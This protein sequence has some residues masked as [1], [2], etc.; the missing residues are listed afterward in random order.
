MQK[1]FTGAE[2][3]A[4][5]HPIHPALP[6]LEA[7]VSTGHLTQTA[8][9][10][11]RQRLHEIPPG[12][13]P[14]LWL[15]GLRLPDADAAAEDRPLDEEGLVRWLSA[16]SGLPVEKIDPLQLEVET[17]VQAIPAGFARHHSILALRIEQRRAVVACADSFRQREWMPD[18][19]RALGREIQPVLACPSDILRHTAEFYRLSRSVEGAASAEKTAP[20]ENSLEQLLSLGIEEDSERHTEAITD[21]LLRY[22]LE[23]RASDIHLEPRRERAQLRL[24]ID[25]MLHPVYSFPASVARAIV[26]RLKVLGRMDAAEK[27]RPQDGRLRTRGIEGGEVEFRLSTL[28]TAHGEKL[29]AR[30][31]DPRALFQDFAQLGLAGRELEEWQMITGSQGGIALVV[32]PTGSGKT[33]TLYTTLRQLADP[34]RNVCTVEDPIEIVEPAFNQTQVH[35]EIGLDFAAGIRAL[36]R[37]DPDIIMVGEIRDTETA[38]MAVQAALTGHRVLATLHAGHSAAAVIRLLDLG[39]PSYLVRATL[40][41]V[42]AQRLVRRLCTKCRQPAPADSE[43]WRR[44]SPAAPPPQVQRAIG[45]AAC[46]HSGY[47]G[48]AGLFEVLSLDETVHALLRKNTGPDALSKALRRPGFRT[49]REVAAARVAAGE[50]SI[51]EALRAV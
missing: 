31:L 34:V 17:I 7:L 30:I 13:P 50:I 10:A 2:N 40:T 6:F 48:R 51:E 42:M 19:G 8:A 11:L 22:A 35:P 4:S 47:R 3:A 27:R 14:L 23:Q 39:V 46:R 12:T 29:V 15:A 37:Q 21:W 32:G 28:P 49:L 24:R 5:T 43:L 44:L 16:Y 20:R 9:Q 26:G 45:C 38:R 25:G 18:L 36:L 33:T 41:G 1:G